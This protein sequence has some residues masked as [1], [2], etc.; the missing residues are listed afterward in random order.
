MRARLRPPSLI[1]QISILNNCRYWLPALALAQSTAPA[2]VQLWHSAPVA[3]SCVIS[4]P[5]FLLSIWFWLQRFFFTRSLARPCPGNIIL[6]IF[7][8]LL[9][10]FSNIH[11]LPGNTVPLYPGARNGCIFFALFNLRSSNLLS[12]HTSEVYVQLRLPLCLDINMVPA[13]LPAALAA[14]IDRGFRLF[15]FLLPYPSC[16]FLQL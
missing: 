5:S 8:F 16:L 15:F 14:D 7:P 3:L 12:W 4:L 1:T 9:S 2:A 10:R 13:Y 6:T 11:C